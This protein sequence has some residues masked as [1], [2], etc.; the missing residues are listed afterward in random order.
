[1]R[2]RWAR[3]SQRLRG[4]ALIV[5]FA[6]IASVGV[7]TVFVVLTARHLGPDGRGE[8][9]VAFTIAWA[10]TSV[11]DLGT[12]ISGRISLL[13]PDNDVRASDVVSLV[14]ALLPFQFVLSSAVVAVL[15]ATSLQLSLGF[16]IATV[17]LSMATMMFNSATSFF[18]GLRRYRDVLVV[19][20]CLAGI[21]VIALIGLLVSSRLTPTS[22][23]LTMAVGLACG[24]LWFVRGSGAIEQGLRSRGATRWRQLIID[25][26]SPMAGFI[27]AFIAFRFDRIVLAIVAGTHSLGIYAVALTVP[28][29]LRILP[30]AVA[31]VVSD[32]GRSHV[33]TVAGLRRLTRIFV[34]VHT[35]VLAVAA[36]AGW[37]LLPEV[38]GEGFVESRDLLVVVTVAEA[39]L[40]IH[41]MHQAL[42]VG[43]GRPK[44]IGVPQVAGAAVMVILDLVMIP[45]WGMQGAAWAL[46]FGYSVLA[47][48]ST[49]WTNY[50]LRR[51]RP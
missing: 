21:Q 43:F 13:D 18:F 33:D 47:F 23:V 11:A 22:A 14:A 4:E 34:V 2:E 26:L 7:G 27:A 44:G 31:Q 30:S 51:N 25:G 45:R 48:A 49:T 46:L 50:E 3:V 36:V 12:S 39:V 29:T 19:E 38:F 28:G 42:L 20:A 5:L 24:S 35:L 6:R 40:S 15:S 37:F 9:V 17:A 1:M 41:L 32:R 10:T 16:S 8:V